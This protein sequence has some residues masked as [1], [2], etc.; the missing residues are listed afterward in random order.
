MREERLLERIRAQGK[1]PGRNATEDPKKVIVSVL[2]HLQ[3]ILNTRQGDVPIAADYGIPDFTDFR[4]TFPFS[5]RDFERSI[6]KAIEKYEPRLKR[7]RVKF[8]PQEEDRLSLT[9]KIL[10]R[11]YIGDEPVVFESELGAD[12]KVRVKR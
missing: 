4:N 2:R 11:L 10:G 1:N 8:I 12:G 7:P 9:F 3:L 6:C 5:M